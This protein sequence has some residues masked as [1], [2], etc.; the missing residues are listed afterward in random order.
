MIMQSKLQEIIEKIG[1]S[2][3]DFQKNVAFHGQDHY[4]GMQIM[5]T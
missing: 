5:Q 3:M 1:M 4:K 2:E